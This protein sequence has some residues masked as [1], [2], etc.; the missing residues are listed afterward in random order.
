MSSSP[1]TRFDGSDIDGLRED[2]LSIPKKF[3]QV[4]RKLC[5]YISY[6]LARLIFVTESMY[7]NLMLACSIVIY[8][9]LR[10]EQ[11]DGGD[12]RIGSLLGQPPHRCDSASSDLWT[13]VRR[14]TRALVSRLK[15]RCGCPPHKTIPTLID[16]AS[17]N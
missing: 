15:P 13:E 7:S 8:P 9:A 12:S 14:M 5:R 11:G 1:S 4:K 16:T 3:L 2:D 17:A 6:V 10:R